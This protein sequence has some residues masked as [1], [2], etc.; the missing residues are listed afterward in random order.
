MSY[1][2][3]IS[4]SKISNWYD[5]VMQQVTITF[6]QVLFSD[7]STSG[8]KSALI[9]RSWLPA[10]VAILMFF[11]KFL[12]RKVLTRCKL[13]PWY[14]I[15]QKENVKLL[16]CDFFALLPQKF[17]LTSFVK[18]FS[19]KF[20]IKSSLYCDFSDWKHV[21]TIATCKK[22]TFSSRK[23]R[24]TMFCYF[25]KIRSQSNDFYHPFHAFPIK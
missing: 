13:V 25:W 16:R 15:R 12:M 24:K 8:F 22:K 14:R 7:A 18:R 21:R 9:I 4:Q 19:E 3:R 20:W 10:F 11:L 5:F 23:S 6:R 2:Y 1:S 17:I